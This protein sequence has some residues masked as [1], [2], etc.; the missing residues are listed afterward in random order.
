[1]VGRCFL[2]SSRF[3]V[4]VV[5]EASAKEKGGGGR[6]AFWEMVFWWTRKPLASARAV[7]AGALLPEDV[8]VRRFIR[9]VLRVE[10]G[11]KGLV[12]NV[13]HRLN[14]SIPREWVKYF[15]G[16]RLLDPFAGFGSIPLEG[17]RLGLDVTAVELLPSAYVFLK[18]VLEYPAK[19]GRDLIR[20]VE[21]WGRW[22][23]ERLKEDPDI[24]ELYDPDVA[25]YIGS[26]EVKCPHCGR[27]T[28]I[29]GN[30]WLARVR[31]GSV[32]ES[33]SA[34]YKRLAWMSPKVE[35]DSVKIE[36]VDVNRELKANRIG[37]RVDTGKGVVVIG[38]KRFSVPK[39]NIQAR[40][41]TVTC[42]LCGNSIRSIDPETGRHYTDTKGLPKPLRKRLVWF[43]KYALRRYHEGDESLAKPRLLVKV[44]IKERRLEFEPCIEEDNETL[45]DAEEKMKKLL[46]EGDPDIPRE[47]V[48]KYEV[49]RITPVLGIDSWYQLF[50]PRQLLTLVKL[51]KLIR[52]A[53]KRVEEEKLKQAWCK[54]EAFNYA[55]AVTTYLA[56][57]LCKLVNYNSCTTRWDSTWWKIGETLSTRGIAMNWNWCDINPESNFIGSWSK[58]LNSLINGLTY[59]ISAIQEI[60]TT[61]YSEGKFSGMIVDV[62]FDDATVLN[63]L[64]F[65]EKFDLIVTDPPYYDD[66]PYTELSDFYYVWLKRALS[67]VEHDR[68]KPRFHPEAFFRKVGTKYV[69]IRTQWEE[70]A[71]REVGLNPPRIGPNAT[72][73]EGKRY[74]LELLRRSFITMSDKLRDDGVLVTYYAHTN[75]EAWEALLEAGWMAGKLRI[76]NAFPL[77]TESLQRVTA[78]GKMALDTSIIV[79]WRKG[80]KGEADV[81][82]LYRQSVEAGAERALALLEGGYRGINLFI[83]TLSAILSTYTRYQKLIGL[84]KYT[85]ENLVRNYIYPATASALAKALTTYA[86]REPAKEALR[87]NTAIFYL[88]AKI[89]FPR[90]PRV[91]R[92]VIDRSSLTMLSIGTRVEYETLIALNLVEKKDSRFY[93]LEP[94]SKDLT[95]LSSF[96][97]NRELDPAEPRIRNAVDALHV[98]EY[99]S[100]AYPQR[101]YQERLENLR[102]E[103]PSQVEEALILAKTLYRLLPKVDPEYMLLQRIAAP[104]KPLF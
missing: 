87:D 102:A 32:S 76:T 42:L 100:A 25:V 46:E 70:Y 13:P 2:E 45:E 86:G 92:R 37:A 58:S 7:I 34:V 66:V 97:K 75:P 8:D 41:E 11:G 40:R 39:P 79:V 88:L 94:P 83:G 15:E 33:G 95:K 4:D 62:L 48:P 84:E 49:R 73:E 12:G 36:V 78:R 61:L 44:R 63:R 18:A 17:L 14:P 77:I 91:G 98:I 22:V 89:L 59:L 60:F 24:Q 29:V 23:T 65:N 64:G 81:D 82:E 6:P 67:N 21:R 74:F 51:V 28:P 56:I 26:W 80:V 101:V 43:V 53:G 19:Y 104:V 55:E 68:L 5:N 30:W 20:D 72:M 71:R 16:K 1:M 50:N 9:E 57:A 35:G 85:V 93:L 90:S 54:E 3:P 52:E 69:E 27:W 10:S 47:P 99:Y 31:E 103:Y 38:S 96:L